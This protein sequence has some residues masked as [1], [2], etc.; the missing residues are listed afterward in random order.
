MVDSRASRRDKPDLS[1]LTIFLDDFLKDEAS[2]GS[3]DIL[4]CRYRLAVGRISSRC[5]V[6][7]NDSTRESKPDSNHS[8][9]ASSMIGHRIVRL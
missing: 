5:M 6:Y 9:G 8:N 1:D 4:P 2:I 7:F 3:F